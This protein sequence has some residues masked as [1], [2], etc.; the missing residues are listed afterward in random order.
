M[1]VLFIPFA[2]RA[3]SIS[4]VTPSTCDA[5]QCLTVSIVTANDDLI[6]CSQAMS[7]ITCNSN[8]G[9][10]YFKNGDSVRS[11]TTISNVKENSLTA[12]VGFPISSSPP[13]IWD[14]AIEHQGG[15]TIWKTGA[16][17][18][19]GLSG[20]VIDSVWPSVVF[21]GRK[22]AI[23]IRGEHTHFKIA[24][25][26]GTANNV[27]GIF[28]LSGAS[29]VQAD[30]FIITNSTSL[31]AFFTLKNDAD[32]GLFD[33]KINQGNALPS[34]LRQGALAIR[35]LSSFSLRDGCIA[36]Y[37]F[38]DWDTIAV[39]SSGQGN[40]G[41]AYNTFPADNR[42]GTQNAADSFNGINS[43]ITVNDAP[44]LR[45]GTITVAAWVKL[46]SLGSDRKIL[47]KVLINGNSDS[48][49][50]GIYSDNKIDF[51]IYG[52]NGW[53]GVRGVSGG[54]V[55]NTGVWYFVAATYDGNVMT[56][57]LNGLVDR[58][59]SVGEIPIQYSAGQLMIGRT[60]TAGYFKGTIDD[61]LMFDR[62]LS[63]EDI[64]ALY[65]LKSGDKPSSDSA[66]PVVVPYTPKV[67][68]NQRPTLLWRAVAKATAYTLTI[69][70]DPAF[71]SVATKVPMSDTV[72][73]PSANL[74]IGPIFWRVKSDLSSRW[75]ATDQILIQSDTIPFLKRYDGGEIKSLK[76]KFE[77]NKVVKAALYRIEI[78]YNA[79]FSDIFVSL[80]LTDT[81]YF[82]TSNM[83]TG[84]CFWRVSSDRNSAFFC[85]VDS[86][87]IKA[88]EVQIGKRQSL[89]PA[90]YS[91][92]INGM[93]KN[94]AIIQLSLP[95]ASTVSLKFFSIQG[96]LL[97]EFSRVYTLP[98][99]FQASVDMS[100]FP[101]GFYIFDF[102]AGPSKITKR[103]L[104]LF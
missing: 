89:I 79:S 55:L 85:P 28:L 17:T 49:N 44:A 45:P 63:E 39:D 38:C 12:E 75:S 91:C 22:V 69:A 66:I 64:Q 59:I 71:S 11:A 31:R 13:G 50:L 8:V 100:G 27:A 7:W 68:L 78:A 35:P 41:A 32:T 37:Q 25:S 10:V 77:W 86:L 87:I 26:N 104:R 30:S 80:P 83:K 96:K 97:K 88:P 43:I 5:G 33:L 56:T 93:S 72:F 81:A 70:T 65:G 24:Q 3:Q 95:K 82:P 84:K 9:R 34:A 54:T 4:T 42:F 57:Y 29:A 18:L 98:G 101:G 76:P 47:G 36:Y 2:S 23:N 21:Q 103:M 67:T 53:Y 16:F 94:G 14:V 15:A 40:N 6:S 51:Y 20:P 58:R 61:V 62:A 60:P 102:Q 46:A 99:Y 1:C 48:Y 19:N 74:P 73:T 52:A 90:Q 92:I